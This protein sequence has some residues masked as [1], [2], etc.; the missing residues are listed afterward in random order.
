MY[1][2]KPVKFDQFKEFVPSSSSFYFLSRK[3]IVTNYTNHES[4]IDVVKDFRQRF[5]RQFGL[6]IA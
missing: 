2:N 6:T 1:K 5:Y 4:R 3:C